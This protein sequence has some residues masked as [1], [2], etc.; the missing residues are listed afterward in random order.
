[1]TLGF[2]EKTAATKMGA[3]NSESDNKT[4]PVVNCPQ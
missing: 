1:M 3:G 2:L 4:S